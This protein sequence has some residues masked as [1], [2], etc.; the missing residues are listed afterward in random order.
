MSKRFV[1]T[2]SSLISPSEASFFPFKPFQRIM[3]RNSPINL[4]ILHKSP[5]QHNVDLLG[6][7]FY[8]SASL[9]NAIT[10]DMPAKHEKSKVLHSFK[11]CFK[12]LTTTKKEPVANLLDGKIQL[13]ILSYI[14]VNFQGETEM[15]FDNL[16][17]S[18]RVTLLQ[19]YLKKTQL[20]SLDANNVE[21]RNTFDLRPVYL[22]TKRLERILD[23]LCK[24]K[25]SLSNFCLT[26]RK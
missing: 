8:S 18:S 13:Y 4:F 22:N 15:T 20:S 5:I 3:K 11:A 19:M 14:S 21:H 23:K 10:D 26:N 6:I 12:V 7:L 24:V 9:F 17:K 1:L 16:P 2:L 25:S